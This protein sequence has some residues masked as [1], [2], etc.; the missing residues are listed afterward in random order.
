[1]LRQRPVAHQKMW[2][3]GLVVTL[4]ATAV[5]VSS[6]A[7]INTSV[8]AVSAAAT[9]RVSVG[10][11]ARESSQDSSEPSISANG[12]WIAFTT[13]EP[14]DP[15]DSMES[16]PTPDED[17]VED[18]PDADVYVRDTVNNTTTLISHSR[19]ARGDVVDIG[20]A[21]GESGQPSISADGRF[22]AFRTNTRNL[23][24]Q[25]VPD[26]PEAPRPAWPEV[27]ILICD[28][29]ADGDGTMNRAC[30]FTHISGEEEGAENPNIS[31]DGSRVSYDVPPVRV[32]TVAS[33]LAPEPN[34]PAVAPPA[35]DPAVG[36]ISLVGLRRDDAGRLVPPTPTD[37]TF[38]SV[39]PSLPVG[40]VAYRL[41]SQRESA[42][43]AGGEHLAFVATY[44]HV[45]P[46]SR[47]AVRM[48]WVTYDY[49]ITTGALSRMDVDAD[50]APIA[51]QGR[52]FSSPALSGDGRR[53][54]YAERLTPEQTRIRLYD[55]DPDGDGVLWPVPGESLGFEVASRTGGGAE[56]LGGAPGFS[57]DGRYLAFTTPSPDMHNGV[58]DAD[59][60]GSCLGSL[61][62]SEVPLSWCDVVVRD[63]VVDRRREEQDRARLPAELASPSVN[64]NCA[65]HKPGATCE[66]GGDSGTPGAAPIGSRVRPL[67]GSP[68]L[69]ADG[70][71]V[72][73]GS[74]AADLVTDPNDANRKSDVFLRRFKPALSGDPLDLGDVPLGSAA[75]GDLPL[76]HIGFGPLPVSAV[77]VKGAHPEDFDVFPGE[78]CT[79][80]P[81]HGTERCTVSVRFR[82]TV[83]GARR[84]TVH[85]E[86]HGAGTPL[87]VAVTGVGV[88]PPASG[89]EATPESLNFGERDVLDTSPA[90]TVTVSNPGNAPLRILTV[91]RGIATPTSF[92]DDYEISADTCGGQE[93]APGATCQI[94][95]RHK[96]KAVGAR[97]GVLSIEYV[98]TTTLT[99]TVALLG[100]GTPPP[101]SGFTAT[102]TSLN[103][104]ERGVLRTSPARTVTVSNPG[105]APL[106]VIS[107]KLGAATLTRFPTDYEISAD[108]CGGREVPAGATCRITVRHKPK[109]VGA[110]PGVL[111]IVYRGTGALT[112]TVALVGAGTPP[113]IKAQPPMS[114]AGR[115]IQVSG[116]NFPPGSKIKLSLYGMPG[117][118]DATADTSG[119]FRAAFLIMPNTWTGKHPLTGEVQPASAPG[120]VGPLAA[121]MDFLI[122]PG[123]PIPPDFN[124]RK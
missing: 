109:A 76:T 34:A 78:T 87:E 21:W 90:Q 4:A 63:L 67:D 83:L 85:V 105:E 62:G 28:R 96:P 46:D 47:P 24:Y 52:E 72:A 41:G 69:S 60:S 50:G 55:R 57:A 7:F 5:V 102:P 36:W 6:L 80:T 32:P 45:D 101:T 70:S 54:A 77:T 91:T 9:V 30:T 49:D 38:V 18:G 117:A 17:R 10:N 97:P 56:G 2:A 121:T 124:I 12:R 113:T 103:F 8:A 11:G 33:R 95:V 110:R 82:P 48:R 25:P 88:P 64:T 35:R 71:A 61:G 107:V 31:A 116:D 14:F 108:T 66:G 86:M 115:V 65:A 98:G 53:L 39:P 74:T 104:G 40:S 51:V 3:S 1:M 37:R 120:L 29:D 42:L 119:V 58:D 122:V 111:S 92:P 26:D 44:W 112:H 19:I 114:P 118:T 27:K 94:S 93:V 79:T 20:P 123:S 89:F 75:I 99:H 16:S 15:V 68:V 81:L 73:Y 84:A 59:R 13:K 106:R 43:A 100:T 23:I 22:V